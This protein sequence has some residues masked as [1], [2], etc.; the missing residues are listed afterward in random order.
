VPVEATVFV[1]DDS[2]EVREALSWMLSS[3][4]L[5]VAGYASAKDYLEAYDQAK[6][7]CLILDVRMPGMGGLDLQQHLLSRGIA[8]PIIFLTGHG[9]ACMV[10]QAMKAG[11]FDFIEKPFDPEMLLRSVRQAIAED[12]HRRQA[13]ESRSEIKARLS[14]LTPREEQVL[15]LLTA[16][17]SSKGIAA[18]LGL[19][20]RTVEKHRAK[21]MGRL[22]ASS[23]ADLLRMVLAVRPGEG[24][25]AS[26][27]P[28]PG[29]P[30]PSGPIKE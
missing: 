11:A 16:G 24:P 29:N 30:R 28:D 27:P 20:D 18:E 14:K 22:Q 26:L 25:R 19:S 5:S 15:D 4:G 10:V 23:L 13:E 6:M 7:G 21:I 1:V 12:R 2:Q 17:K 8:I 3:D 9:E